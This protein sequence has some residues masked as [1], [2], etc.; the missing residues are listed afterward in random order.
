MPTR[1]RPLHSAKRFASW[2]R[3][4]SAT[5][6]AAS[7]LALAMPFSA[8]SASLAASLAD[9]DAA[10]E[11]GY[12]SPSQALVDIVD[13]Q[14][15]PRA[16]LSP[17]GDWLLL[18]DDP[19]L[20]SLEDLARDE[21]RLA[22][23]R[24]RPATSGP[25]RDRG[26]AG[27]RLVSVSTG[28]EHTVQGLPPEPEIGDLTF[29]PDGRRFA[30][31]DTT[32][33]A[34]EL[35][36]GDL[37]S[38]TVR[39]L[40]SRAVNQAEPL[41][42]AW[43]PD[44][45]S[46]VVALVPGDRGAPPER[47][48]LPRS[49]VIEES[50]ERSAPARTYQDLLSD[51]HDERLFEHWFTSQLARV[52]VDGSVVELGEPAIFSS[53]DI[54]P[55]GS[56]LLVER[57]EPPWS[58]RVPISRFPRRIE[59]WNERGERIAE[60]ASIPLQEEVPIAFGS[61]PTGPRSVQWRADQPATLFWVEAVDG[62]DARREPEAGARDRMYLLAPPYDEPAR[63]VGDLALRF[64][65]V[66]WQ[67]GGDALVQD[68][69]WQTRQIRTLLV[70]AEAWSTADSAAAEG[71]A[72]R[73]LFDRSYEDRYTDPGDPLTVPSGRGDELLRR[74]ADGRLVL[75][76]DG[77][78][79]EG[80]R[81]FVDLYDPSTGETERIFRSEGE[82]FEQ[83][84]E[85][86]ATDAGG[87]PTA[88]LT[89]RESVDEPPNYYARDLRSGELRPLTAFPHPAPQL[90]GLGKE[91]LRYTRADGVE[92]TGTLYTP[93]GWSREQGPLPT[94]VWAYPREF[95]SADAAGQVRDSPYRFRRIDHWSP[96]S[97]LALGYAVLDDPA[98]PIVGEGEEE[99]ND[100]YVEQLVASAAAAVEEL[101]TRGV[102]QRDR[103]AIG[104]HS[105]GAF[106]TANLLAHS[107][108]FAAG[109]AR[110]G[111]YNRTLTPFGF[112]A[113]Q[114]SV[115]E[116]PE[117]YFAMSPFMHAEKVNEPILLIHG[118]DDNNS[119]TFPMQSERFFAA[120]KGLGGTARLVM[121]PL[122]SHGYRARLSLLHMLWEQERWL[123][124]WIGAAAAQSEPEGEATS[125]SAGAGRR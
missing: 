95:K 70:P 110:S 7:M 31:L 23:R 104:G 116:A 43:A 79:P 54:S 71:A 13:Q 35:W 19:G 103:I 123:E 96:V 106:M 26:A 51:P 24:I 4:P 28:E 66:R 92:L 122:E 111:A 94:L 85:V 114:R 49:P 9:G 90:R 45:Q 75:V 18:L 82:W 25:S 72:P 15:T 102:A 2:A 40:T 48:P 17:R 86:L 67:A 22:G 105:Y 16:R 125:E 84:L 14:R 50:R 29:A 81:P 53:Y 58:Y 78:S 99:P 89:R 83:P 63:S 69:W 77:A 59:L 109:I 10:G 37:E 60:V 117:V 112:Q 119:G 64:A 68:L 80:D 44:S 115:W 30:F 100:R 121:L 62:G 38:R 113:E 107:D 36:V 32:A 39:R 11:H 55:D 120:V 57:L 42:L 124:E 74:L 93:P 101:V 12:R 108:L 76:G 46:L 33:T 20:P 27:L 3:F 118:Q 97:F 61:V 8:A 91:L 47:A 88:L 98:M 41:P 87:R 56:A 52:G 6:A 73:V 34:I 65:G 1:P 5:F 21:L